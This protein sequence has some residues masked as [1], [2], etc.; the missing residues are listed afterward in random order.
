MKEE[1]NLIQKG[2][3]EIYFIDVGQGDSTLIITPDN[4]KILID[5]GPDDSC[6]KFLKKKYLQRKFLIK[7]NKLHIDAIIMTH[8]DRDHVK[9]LIN[10]LN[11]KNIIIKNIF[12]NGIAK[13][14]TN[15]KNKYTLGKKEGEG[16]E[17]KLTS[18]YD[19]DL[20][21]FNDSD[22]K[23]FS[24]LFR[25]NFWNRKCNQKCFKKRS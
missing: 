7:S 24:Q 22:K 16:K 9:G 5:G 19:D 2:M 17:M 14:A 23:S 25:F 11:D 8:A 10:I 1:D 20:K 3:L 6:H 13:F 4:K 15:K 18:L 21:Y 12:H